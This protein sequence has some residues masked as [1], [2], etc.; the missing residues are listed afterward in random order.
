MACE[1]LWDVAL[2]MSWACGI[3]CNCTSPV[4]KQ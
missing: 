4:H 2:F 1:L 3:N